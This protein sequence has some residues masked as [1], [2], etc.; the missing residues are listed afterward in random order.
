LASVLYPVPYLKRI[1][2]NFFEKK[3]ALNDSNTQCMR[4][5]WRAHQNAGRTTDG[6]GSKK[7]PPQLAVP[8]LMRVEYWPASGKAN[9]CL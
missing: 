8:I 2:E 6:Q 7:P 3:L 4:N 1:P 9:H 5:K